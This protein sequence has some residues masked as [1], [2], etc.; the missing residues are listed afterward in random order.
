[1]KLAYSTLACPDWTIEKIVSVG[2]ENG[3][4]GIEFRGLGAD[5]DLTKSAAFSTP[6]YCKKTRNLLEK[7]GLMTACI[8]TSM[9]VVANAQND[10]AFIASINDGR[11]N[12]E[13]AADMH[14]PVIR[15]FCGNL[16]DN[17]TKE[18]AISN[19][20]RLLNLLGDYAEENAVKI[21]V[22][23]HDSFISSVMLAELLIATDHIAVGALWDVHHP[24]RFCNE[25]P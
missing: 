15:V 11:K 17:D 23:T 24:Y 4:E 20:A 6:N 5:V 13:I 19:G 1:M 12:I 10:D 7:A 2:V 16:P 3:Y 22:E 14:A 8:S 21:A 25:S 9:Q 18:N